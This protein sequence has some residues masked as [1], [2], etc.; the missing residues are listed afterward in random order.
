MI[1]TCKRKHYCDRR[2]HNERQAFPQSSPSYEYKYEVYDLNGEGGEEKQ[3]FVC[4]ELTELLTYLL[5]HGFHP[6]TIGDLVSG[7]NI[8]NHK[9][10][11]NGV[12]KIC[13]MYDARK[14]AVKEGVCKPFY[15]VVSG[16]DRYCYSKAEGGCW[17]DWTSIQEVRRAFTVQEGI[18][19][20][21]MLKEK[22]PQPR[23]NRF[24]VLG[25][26]D[27]EFTLCYGEDDPRWPEETT[28]RETY[29]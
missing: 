3:V 2:A 21:R 24:S 13:D 16:I 7:K 25:G 9:V 28:E 17:A 6:A 4:N 11:V 5:T 27:V 10:T 29:D 15:I 18:R 14:A 26:T 8:G 19:Q 1:Q 23:Y 12:C 20:L 22:Y